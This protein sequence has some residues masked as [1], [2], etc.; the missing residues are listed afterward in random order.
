MVRKSAATLALIPS[1][2]LMGWNGGQSQLTQGA[3][4]VRS[5]VSGA[6]INRTRRA[7]DVD[8]TSGDA[9]SAAFNA[10]VVRLTHRLNSTL[11][12]ASGRFDQDPAAEL[13]VLPLLARIKDLASLSRESDEFGFLETAMIRGRNNV[14]ATLR[15][16][17]DAI[18][19]YLSQPAR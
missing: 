5:E 14:D 7:I 17:T 16:A 13:P 4:A 18:E 19:A 10:L 2:M 1:A 15:M 6:E 12:T 11:Y 8:R 9:D 3:S